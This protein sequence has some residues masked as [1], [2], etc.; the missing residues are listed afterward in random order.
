MRRT[1]LTK[2]AVMTA[3]AGLMLYSLGATAGRAAEI[4]VL[5]SV[6]LTSALD[7]IAPKFE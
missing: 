1:S 2:R 3:A 6:A 4:K 7:K 5:T